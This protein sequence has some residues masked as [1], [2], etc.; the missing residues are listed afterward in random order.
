MNMEVGI[1]KPDINTDTAVGITGGGGIIIAGIV[2]ES[3]TIEVHDITG[4][5]RL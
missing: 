4:A 2:T 1:I 3:I 5:A